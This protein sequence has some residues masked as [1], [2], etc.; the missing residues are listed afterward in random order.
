MSPEGVNVRHTDRIW[1]GGEWVRAHSGRMIELVSPDTEEVIGAV[2]EADE[3]DMNAAVA[4]ARAAFDVGP[5]SGLRPP[6]RI[7]CLKRM[8]Q[9]LHGRTGEIARAW[10]AQMGGLASFAVPMTAGST[11]ALEQIIAAAETF[12]FV[13]TRPSPVVKSAIVAHEPVGVVAA[14]RRG[15]RRSGSCPTRWSTRWSPAARSS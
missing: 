4:A 5:W 6:E 14:S 9:H 2:A 13:E 1:I 12:P 7:A 3:E 11:M 8:A 15:T 10:T